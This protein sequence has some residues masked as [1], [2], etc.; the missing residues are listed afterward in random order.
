[1]KIKLIVL[2]C[3]AVAWM[4]CGDQKSKE[5][6]VE[7]KGESISEESKNE[8]AEIDPMSNK[9]IG[10]ISSID[11]G[12]IDPDLAVKGETEFKA[13]CTACHKISK[14]HIGPA[15]KGVTQRRSPEWIMNMILNPEDMVQ[16]DP[17][18]KNLL[19]EYNGAPMANQN[20]TQEEARSILEYFRTKT[21]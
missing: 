6:P 4:S 13:K 8:A 10:P 19:I 16:N 7:T 5:S 17:I 20:L 1:M 21:E 11:L 12:D 15:L 9:G 2:L 14:R 3:L 18:A